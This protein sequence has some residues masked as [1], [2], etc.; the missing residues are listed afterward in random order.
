M[1]Q[2]WWKSLHRQNSPAEKEEQP[3]TPK[4]DEPR[5]KAPEP[6]AFNHRD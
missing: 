1:E 3:P 4:I 6:E 2:K 5:V